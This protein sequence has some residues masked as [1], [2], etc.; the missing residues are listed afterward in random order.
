VDALS[1][2]FLTVIR[3]FNRAKKPIASICV[4]S[5]ALGHAGILQGKQA[6]IYHQQGGKRKQQL[7]QTG[8][9]FVDRPVIKD[10]YIITSTSPGTALEVA[11]LLLEEVTST[12]NATAL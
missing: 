4:S 7:E 12:G 3:H 6:T 5:L 10:Q 2:E 11:F 9:R 8:A 1:E